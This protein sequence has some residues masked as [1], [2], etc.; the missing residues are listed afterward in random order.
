MGGG[1]SVAQIP[2]H[3]DK[4]TFQ[5]ITGGTFN[6]PIFD[7]YAVDGV[8]TRDQLLELSHTTDCF[9]SFDRQSTDIHGRENFD[10]VRLVQ[11]GLQA[12]GLVCWLLE[13]QDANAAE[14]RAG[15]VFNANKNNIM[16]LC[17]GMDK[18]RCVL[19]FITKNY[20]HRVSQVQNTTDQCQ[21]EFNY[22]VRQKFPSHMLGL[23]CDQP[24]LS[25][26][27][28][29]ASPVGTYLLQESARP[30]PGQSVCEWSPKVL[31]MTQD[32]PTLFEAQ[33]DALFKRVVEVT[34]PKH[35]QEY[36]DVPPEEPVPISMSATE[37]LV[38]KGHVPLPQTR[39]L[40]PS[41]TRED[42]QFFQWMARCCHGI[43][44]EKRAVYCAAFEHRGVKTVQ[45]LANMMARDPNYLMLTGV[46]ER[47][48]DDIALAVS[49]LGLGYVPVRDFSNSTTVESA[50]YAM[51]KSCEAAGD[52]E[53]GAN[54]LSCIAR[55]AVTDPTM[56]H[57]L[58][59]AGCVEPVVKILQR[60]LGHATC[61]LQAYY[62]LQGLCA[63]PHIAI[64]LGNSSA[65]DVVPRALQSHINNAVVVEEGC[66]LIAVMAQ[67]QENN[68]KLGTA[69][70]CDVVMKGLLKHIH[71]RGVAQAGCDAANK[72]AY[73]NFENV[74][75]LSYHKACEG[76]SSAIVTHYQDANVAEQ[77]FRAM[78]IL[79][80]E[81]ENRARM[82]KLGACQGLISAIDFHINDPVIVEF[83]IRVMSTM[84]IGNA[85][86]RTH[87]G[88]LG[89]PKSVGRVLEVYTQ[90]RSPSTQLQPL[91]SQVAST[92]IFGAP[93]PK[94]V[95]AKSEAAPLVFDYP[96]IV[97]FAC[98]A[99]YS[100][101]A[102]SPQNQGSFEPTL[103]LLKAIAATSN[104][105][106]LMATAQQ[107][108]KKSVTAGNM[109]LQ[110]PV[111]ASALTA[112]IEGMR[113]IK[114][115]STEAVQRTS[116]A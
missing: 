7:D 116:T 51:R 87:F 81:P 99:V 21:I 61:V 69:G 44:P 45:N 14:D 26:P 75:K 108:A 12:R 68:F 112:E 27:Q 1:I 82:G 42:A 39:G 11:Q 92:N 49:D 88:H 18:T 74:G 10:R 77:A 9:L 93:S 41:A 89:A 102:G 2:M 3:I 46:S 76:L 105:Y 30:M 91:D 20:I 23:V 85:N 71:L 33:M 22:A 62:A 113:L 25:E 107:Q 98:T 48:A 50:V 94:A 60:N 19:H 73:G 114:A 109:R 66:K 56:P 100:L 63:D 40:P 52:P 103:P 34:R 24:L 13:E 32:E 4:E 104:D 111:A 17:K 28:A 96:I 59:E 29:W 8:M 84:I 101:S 80:V 16:S 15:V 38:D 64:K 37:P 43:K 55:I 35:V 58:S 65:C 79:C 53:L 83:G 72:L 106:M 5:R 54:A 31:D 36:F 110:A 90:L 47:D 115:E 57:S 70:A 78:N 95:S 6:D 67:N 97:Q 86:N